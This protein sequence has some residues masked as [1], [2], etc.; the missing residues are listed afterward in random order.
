MLT[1]LRKAMCNWKVVVSSMILSCYRYYNL[2]F[3]FFFVE[4]HSRNEAYF[5][6][7][8]FFLEETRF[9]CTSLVLEMVLGVVGGKTSCIIVFYLH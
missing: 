3:F 5:L 6:L 4:R 7:A 9:F 1:I 8:V 2:N